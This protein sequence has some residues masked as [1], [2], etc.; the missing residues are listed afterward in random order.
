MPPAQF[1]QPARIE[2][3][4]EEAV[5][6]DFIAERFVATALPVG[7]VLYVADLPQKHRKE[8][9]RQAVSTA[10]ELDGLIASA[11]QEV[12][13]QTP[14]LVLSDAAQAIFRDLR[15][16]P[17]PPRVV[18]STNSLA[19][20]DNP[21][22]YALSYEYKR[23]NLR[24]LGFNIYEYKPFPLDAPVDYENLVRA[25]LAQGPGERE[26]RVLGGSAIGNAVRGSSGQ[27]GA[28]GDP[29]RDAGRAPGG[30]EVDRRLQRTETRPSF[31]S[32]RPANKPLPVTREGARMGLHAKIVGGRPAGGGHRHP[33]T[34]TRAARTTTPKAPSS[35][36]TR[37][38][39][40]HWRRASSAT[41]HP[42]MPRVV[43]PREKPPVLSGLNYSAGKMF[44]ALPILDFWPWRYAT[45]YEFKPG[46]D[47]PWPLRRQDPKFLQCY[48]PVGD[49]PEVNVGPKWLLVRMLTAFGA[50]LVPI[51]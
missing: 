37:L 41:W 48:E 34:S 8:H 44:E 16:Q 21:V 6:S 24:E 9:P 42:P 19:A 26:N 22:V 17:E 39:R 38:S 1:L 12:L 46:P 50:G 13:L 3:V 43:A 28:A 14:Y 49:F 20:T 4:R 31:F 40:R 51:L 35:S 33:T 11:Q 36:S 25:P 47:C 30:S 10:P 2:R 7:K 23:R 27:P 32:T 29:D 15:Q 5:D 18:V 45:N